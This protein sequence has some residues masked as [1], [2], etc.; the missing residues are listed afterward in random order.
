M[1]GG[2]R[3]HHDNFYYSLPGSVHAHHGL[4][5]ARAFET[6]A[7]FPIVAKRHW[8]VQWFFQAIQK[9]CPSPLLISI[10]F[11]LSIRSGPWQRNFVDARFPQFHMFPTAWSCITTI[12]LPEFYIRVR[13]KV[14][15]TVTNSGSPIEWSF[16]HGTLI[17]APRY[18]SAWKQRKRR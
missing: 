2:V 1:P 3:T 4:F 8:T 13:Q 17:D 16:A 15:F 6:L 5:R 10:A 12:G 11:T 9:T 7:T 18:A 14:T